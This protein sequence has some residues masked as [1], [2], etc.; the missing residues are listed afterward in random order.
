[1]TKRCALLVVLVAI[2]AASC[3]DPG[4]EVYFSNPCEGSVG[5]VYDIVEPGDDVA[6]QREVVNVPGR[7][8][9]GLADLS[10]N[11]VDREVRVTIDGLAGYEE[12]WRRPGTGD[13]REFTFD[14]GLCGEISE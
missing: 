3:G 1:M 9:Q 14:E 8:V 4:F 11:V 7:S 2:G 13:S 6:I 5:F 10:I 12:R